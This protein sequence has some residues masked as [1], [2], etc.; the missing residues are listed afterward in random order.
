[1]SLARLQGLARSALLAKAALPARAGAG[2]PVKLAPRP[3][4]PVSAALAR[5]A[6]QCLLDSIRRPGPFRAPQRAG[7]FMQ[8]RGEHPHT[9]P[10]RCVAHL[11]TLL[12]RSCLTPGHA[13][14]FGAASHLV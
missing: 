7:A 2:A 8:E 12:T 9:Q 3:D 11:C 10:R 6:L 1:M 5:L 4:K 14:N 13:F